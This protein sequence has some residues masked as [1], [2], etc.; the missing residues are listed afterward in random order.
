MPRAGG[1]IRPIHG[2]GSGQLLPV[3]AA[4]RH[5]GRMETLGARLSDHP[6]ENRR[7]HAA[8]AQIAVVAGAVIAVGV[9]FSIWFYGR[10][11]RGVGPDPRNSLVGGVPVGIVAVAVLSLCAAA[12]LVVAAA[13][14]RGDTIVV[15]ER[16]IVRRHGRAEI[17]LPWAA[18]AR[19]QPQGAE[20]P[21]HISHRLG[22][23]YRCVLHLADGRRIAFTS[24]TKEATALTRRIAD[25]L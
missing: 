19:V 13:R 18:V 23:D 4:P 21:A 7:H 11:W 22:I 6:T 14:S 12:A 24:Y 25:S 5:C 16:G 3:A 8:A 20:R 10:P 2:A 9:P 15:Y 1:G 17:T